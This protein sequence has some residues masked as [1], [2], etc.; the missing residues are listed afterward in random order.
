[1]SKEWLLSIVGMFDSQEK[2]KEENPMT[3]EEVI[4]ELSKLSGRVISLFFYIVDEFE[5]AN[6]CSLADGVFQFYI[7]ERSNRIKLRVGT[8]NYYV[9]P[10]E[11]IRISNYA[12]SVSV[13]SEKR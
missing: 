4:N 6:L 11:I 10:D 12:I 2:A 13:K 3:K 7:E 5:E 8:T 1:M 9:R